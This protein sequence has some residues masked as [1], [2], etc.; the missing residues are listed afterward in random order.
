M[1]QPLCHLSS[2]A[3]GESFARIASVDKCAGFPS[4]VPGIA[5]HTLASPYTTKYFAFGWWTTI[6]EVL[7]SG[8]CSQVEVSRTP[9]FSSGR[10]RANS[11]V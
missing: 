3:Q 1:L 5:A 7:C 8:S 11:F 6:A 10:S 9:M 2:G 4:P